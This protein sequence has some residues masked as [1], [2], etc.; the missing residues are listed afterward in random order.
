VLSGDQE[1]QRAVRLWALGTPVVVRFVGARADE[2][3][4]A[5]EAA[6][7]W[8]LGPPVHAACDPVVIDAVLEEPAVHSGDPPVDRTAQ[9]VDLLQRLT[10][11]ITSRV[12]SAQ[13]GSSLLMLHA[14]A[15]ADSDTGATAVLVGPSGV[16]KTTVACALGTS[17]A[18]LTDETAGV[19]PDKTVLPYPKPLSVLS[20]EGSS[21]KEQVAPAS[22]GLLPAPEHCRLAAVV[23]L[24]RS[25]VAPVV[26]QV[27]RVGTVPA[28]ADLGEQTSYLSRMERPLHVIADVLE[29]CGGLLRVTYR[30]AEH[31]R[32]LMAELL[33]GER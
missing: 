32:P 1:D 21:V 28:L 26:P 30:E 25:P 27:E 8:C 18:Y 14:C 9:L 17:W 23:R 22:L 3:A 16:G 31:L 33:G 6:W 13:A 29:H 15:L 10:S 7:A 19:F 24:E 11:D 4:V 20:A 5:L 12:I 2:A